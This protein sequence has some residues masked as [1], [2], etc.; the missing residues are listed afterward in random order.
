MKSRQYHP[1]RIESHFNKMVDSIFDREIGSFFGSDNFVSQPLV[2]ILETAEGYSIEI[3]A[4]GL[5]KGDFEIH[6]EGSFLTV[7][8]RQK[9]EGVRNQDGKILRKEFNFETFS[10]R[11]RLTN[12]IDM[13]KISARYEN[14]V[15]KITL[16]KSESELRQSRSVEVL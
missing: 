9:Q 16:L 2:N 14:G 10:R 3:A 11:F 8:A 1:A 15:L 13:E 12:G 7:S 5:E 6:A 4:P